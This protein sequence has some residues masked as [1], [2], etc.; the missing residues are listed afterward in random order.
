[1]NAFSL[2]PQLAADTLEITR[3]PLCL[4]LLMN[5]AAYPWVILVPQ[6]MG[7][8]EIHELS[9]DEQVQ[10]IRETSSVARAM[11][12]L[13]KPDKM[14]IAALGNRVPQL[15]IHHVARFQND[16]AWPDPVWGRSAATAYADDALTARITSLRDAFTE[17]SRKS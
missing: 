13:F 1:M 7:I 15:H 4:A 5:D 16:P 14:N 10:L 6:R 8:R 3:L 12:A 2:H 11:S 9:D 17:I